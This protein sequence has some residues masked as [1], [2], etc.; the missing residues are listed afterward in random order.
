MILIGVTVFVS[1]WIIFAA[2]PGPKFVDINPAD[3]NSKPKD[4]LPGGDV[5]GVKT[6][7]DFGKIP[8]YFVTNQGQV[9]GQAKFYAKA[10]RYTLW[11][12]K[13]G[14]VFD[15]T[16]PTQE[17]HTPPFGHPFQEGS[18]RIPHS[19]YSPYSTYFTHSPKLERAVS[20][21]VFLD[22]DRNPEIAAIEPAKLKVNYFIG[23]D[24][25]KWHCDVPTSM[26]VLYKSLYKNIDL[27]VYGI[28]KQIE[29]DWIVK[30]GGNPQDIRFEYKNVK[31]TRL[32]DEGNLLI[33]TDF[34]E[35]IHKKPVSY[36]RNKM[37]G[38]DVGAG[39]LT[40]PKD[41]KDI[42]VTFKKIDKNTYGFAVGEYDRSR[43][44]II[45]PVVL[46][47]STYLGGGDD[48]WGYSI[49][50]DGSGNVYVTGVTDST[51]F[52][53]LN[54]YQAYQGG[55][56][57][58]FVAKLD[59]SQSGAASL[60][61]STYLGGESTDYGRGIAVDGSG[62]AYV[63]GETYSTDF[64]TLNQY[65]AD[66]GGGD[67]FV[68]KLDPSQSGAA[69]LLYSTYL[70][71]GNSDYGDDIAVDGSSNA[72]V[73]GNTHST[74]FPTIHQ[75]QADQGGIDVFVAKLDPSQS[76][77]A[78]LLYS[79]YLGGEGNDNG[80]GIAVDGSGNSYVTGN[81]SSTD[82]PT[83]HQYQAAKGGG[84]VFVS[85]LDPSHSGTASLL[86]STCLGGGDYDR[87]FGI[88]V[89]GSGNAYV[90]GDTSSTDFPTLNQY[91]ADKGGWCDVFVAKL[92]PSQSGAASLL[93][94]TYLGGEYWDM[95]YGIAVDGSGNVY[96]T[97]VT[98]STNFPTLNQYQ[99]DQGLDD[100][101]VIKLDPSQSGAASLLYSTYLGGGSSEQGYGIAV[102]DGGNAYVTGYTTSTDFPT[103]NQYQ[104][105]QG[106]EDV[107]VA[108]LSFIDAPTVTTTAVSNITYTS[109]DSGG[110]VTPDGG[111][112]V[113]AR[114]V[115]WSTSPNPTTA[116]SKTSNGTGIGAFTSHITGLTPGTT[117]HV[118]AYA[119][120][121]VGTSYGS[122][123]NFT[124]PTGIIVT[125][126]N[127]GEK[128]GLGTMQNITWTSSGLPGYLRIELW[129]ANKKIGDI[130]VNIP[131]VNGKYPWNVGTL[132]L[133]AAPMTGNDYRVKIITANGLYSDTSDGNFSI[134]KPSLT[135]TSPLGGEK[136][137]KG[138]QHN[139]TWTSVGLTGNVKLILLK[140]GVK[141]GTIAQRIPVVNGTYTWTVGNY[142]AGSNYTVKI[143][144][145]DNLFQRTS[146]TFRIW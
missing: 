20:R 34:G 116:N 121:S 75:Y 5:K 65:Q 30:P 77:A 43:E 125:S 96:V 141:V 123:V 99:A 67:V 138:T 62:N 79:T 6:D 109:A 2:N 35:L 31:G 13:E 72:C 64:P 144:P 128:W 137:Q 28:E 54:Q 114:G 4:L 135:L 15:S 129:K 66:Q 23:N 103:L 113:T 53:T 110:N 51:N 48:D 87:G 117:Y 127:G 38:G 29:Y 59:P 41:R 145:E 94:S 45:D 63:T 82:F 52:P 76:G 11:M 47:F 58:V 10:S 24:K 57:D 55:V 98:D 120:N 122:D 56:Y 132:T 46:A 19:P 88:A 107:F 105:D 71:G 142:S 9:N 85:K 12:T 42:N 115:C 130:A 68:T 36:Q 21:L 100:V 111:A 134:V 108:K 119:T 27:K 33:E 83:I 143:I 104:A 8:L 44:L 146:G 95:G 18:N 92:D 14:L 126:P 70:G 49:A 139:I 61:Y 32:D 25:S 91:Q 118:R 69:S 131:I 16:R 86:Y 89:D 101:F 102:D 17:R 97:G 133:G 136:W 1:I 124:T 81:T 90:T 80:L 50:V 74:D 22:A 40:C 78:S 112:A 7:I 93:Y 73:T 84:D 37:Q 3:L 60:F 140:G 39:L 26:A 106:G